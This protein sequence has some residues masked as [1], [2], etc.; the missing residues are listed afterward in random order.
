MVVLST[1]VVNVALPPLRHGVG[2]SGTGRSWVVNAH[3]LAFGAL[4]LLGGRAADLADARRVLVA[5]WSCSPPP[6]WPLGWPAPPG[7]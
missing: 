1:S 7:C 4:L 2:L 6:R 3:G 5:G